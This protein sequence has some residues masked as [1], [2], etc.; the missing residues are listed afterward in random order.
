MRRGLCAVPVKGK[1]M[2][3]KVRSVFKE[4]KR[5]MRRKKMQG[6]RNSQSQLCKSVLPF[7]FVSFR[8]VE[9][10]FSF[11]DAFAA[12]FG[13][14]PLPEPE[15]EPEPESEPEPETCA[16]GTSTALRPARGGAG[17]DMGMWLLLLVPVPA[18]GAAPVLGGLLERNREVANILCPFSFVSRWRS[19]SD[20]EC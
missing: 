19:R 14:A 11:A 4:K 16:S 9:F 5:K 3:R 7:P 17:L 20:L 6:T 15:P 13:A 2:R 1:L 8:G 12:L 10:F 18:L